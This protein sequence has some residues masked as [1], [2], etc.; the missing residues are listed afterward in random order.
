MIC[1][2]CNNKIDVDSKF[3]SYCGNKVSIE[4]EKTLQIEQSIEKVEF[5]K[6]NETISDNNETKV[7]EKQN[8]S[9]FKEFY[10]SN[11]GAIGRKEFFF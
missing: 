8:D 4:Q 2:K 3:C 9:T 6:A 5:E 7:S 10:F 11:K 1:E